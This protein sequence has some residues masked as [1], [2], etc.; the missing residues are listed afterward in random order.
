MSAVFALAARAGPEW[1]QLVIPQEGV[2][3]GV[4]I[5]LGKLRPQWLPCLDLWQFDV[6]AAVC[7][8]SN[9]RGPTQNVVTKK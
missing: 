9:A 3:L 2:T 7:K 6:S 4:L 5:S 8:S 1:A